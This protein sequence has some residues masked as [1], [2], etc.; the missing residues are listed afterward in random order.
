M[1]KKLIIFTRYPETGTTKTR[2]IPLLGAKGAAEL[3][4]K[5]TEHT[6][7]KLERL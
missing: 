5:M 2:L 1:K 4:R 7:A 6:L 3:H